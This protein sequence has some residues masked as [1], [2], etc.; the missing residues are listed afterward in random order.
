MERLI[1]VAFL[2]MAGCSAEQKAQTAIA[3][4]GPFCETLGFTKNTDGW[5]ECIQ[6]REG[7]IMRAVFR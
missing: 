6:R 4:S 2:A 7:D 5:R 1:L 3:R